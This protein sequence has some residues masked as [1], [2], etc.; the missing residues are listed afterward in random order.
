[1]NLFESGK[2]KNNY[3]LGRLCCSFVPL[4]V[5]GIVCYITLDFNPDGNCFAWIFESRLES[6]TSLWSKIMSSS[7]CWPDELQF[8][9]DLY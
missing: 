3:L 2:N 5:H 6:F 1:M 8:N 9:I 7:I 4:M